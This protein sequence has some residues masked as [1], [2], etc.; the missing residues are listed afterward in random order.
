MPSYQLY[1]IRVEPQA[2]LQYEIKAE[3]E[4]LIG[5][6]TTCSVPPVDDTVEYHASGLE[7]EQHFSFHVFRFNSRP[8][9]AVFMHCYID[10]CQ[11]GN[12]AIP[13]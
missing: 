6:L 4:V 3:A 8:D 12:T 13:R 10:I 7:T 9:T 5:R 1:Y 2:R 11:V